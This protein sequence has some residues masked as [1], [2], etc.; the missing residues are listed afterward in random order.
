MILKQTT[1]TLTTHATTYSFSIPIN[2]TNLKFRERGGTEILQ[3]S[4]DNFTTYYTLP[5]AAERSYIN[6]RSQAGQTLYIQTPTLDGK[7]VEIEYAI[8][9]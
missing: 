5:A 1:L 9:G 3:Y 8:D 7:I 2:A 6:W 4:F